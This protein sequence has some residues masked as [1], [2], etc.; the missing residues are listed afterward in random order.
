MRV[1][2]GRR[3]RSCP[4]RAPVSACVRVRACACCEKG[5]ALMLRERCGPLRAMADIAAAAA[6]AT[7]VM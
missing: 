1:T 7:I 4:G 2:G 5:A 3:V 6:A